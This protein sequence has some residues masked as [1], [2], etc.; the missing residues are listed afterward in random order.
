MRAC[1]IDILACGA[2]KWLLSPWGSGFAYV[3][4][5]L[6]QALEPNVVSWMA[7]RDSDDFT[8][9][10]DYD[11]RYR[12]S[13]RRFE[14]ITL[15][16][17]DLAAMNASLELLLELGMPAISAHVAGLTATV[18]GWAEAE[19]VRA[20]PASA[21]RRAGIISVVPRGDPAEASERLTSAG[22]IHSL[23]EGAI[24][25]SPHCYNTRQEIEQALEVMAGAGLDAVERDAPA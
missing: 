20:T 3:R 2:Q 24:R 25:F 19:G 18:A 23:R 1:A 7:V 14:M 12:D 6:V 11:L 21:E 8:R 10:C 9:L 16:F 13:A 15:P 22:V 4:R 5:E 17:A